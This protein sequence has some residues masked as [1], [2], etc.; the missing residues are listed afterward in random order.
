[1]K[2]TTVVAAIATTVAATNAA[3]VTSAKCPPSETDKLNQ[4]KSER[5]YNQ[6]VI[7]GKYSF[8]APTGEPTELQVR[9]M[10]SSYSCWYYT[11]PAL[12]RLKLSDCDQTFSTGAT[13]NMKKVVDTLVTRCGI[14]LYN[15]TLEPAAN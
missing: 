15:P 5:T 7:D 10:C 14:D 3:D 11:L 4:I 13:V 9:E 1:M 2:F 12:K 6:C 8:V